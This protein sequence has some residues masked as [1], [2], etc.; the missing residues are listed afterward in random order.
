[1]LKRVMMPKRAVMLKRVA[2]LLVA[3]L[4][5]GAALAEQEIMARKYFY[6]LTSAFSAFS[7]K[8]DP[9]ETPVALEV[10]RRV[11]TLPMFADLS[12]EDVDRICEI[13]LG[14]SR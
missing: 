1:M 8:Y 4:L 6:P 7:G 11:L 5:A 2:L 13:V 12:M 10:S 9:A 14:C 3:C